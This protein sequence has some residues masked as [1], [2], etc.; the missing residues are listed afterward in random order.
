MKKTMAAKPKKEKLVAGERKAVRQTGARKEARKGIV[1]EIYSGQQGGRLATTGS[2][3]N[4]GMSSANV[5]AV[6]EFYRTPGV[7][8]GGATVGTKEEKSAAMQKAAAINNAEFQRTRL[9]AKLEKIA[10]KSAAKAGKPVVRKVAVVKSR[11]KK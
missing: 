1:S 6:T 11:S 8:K 2:K 9:G 5:G 7:R 4:R 10:T 3:T